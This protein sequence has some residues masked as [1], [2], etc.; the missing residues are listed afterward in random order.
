M[1]S[2]AV[3][4]AVAFVTGAVFALLAVLAVSLV[5]S[6][7]EPP[8]ALDLDDADQRRRFE[9]LDRGHRLR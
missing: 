4:A 6:P 5:R 8:V 1:S 9:L 2:L 7:A 3:V